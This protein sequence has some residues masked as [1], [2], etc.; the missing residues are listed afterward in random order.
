[1]ICPSCHTPNRDGGRFCIS[2]GYTLPRPPVSTPIQAYQEP[3]PAFTPSGPPAGYPA[4]GGYAPSAPVYAPVQPTPAEAPPA[5]ATIAAPAAVLAPVTRV[6]VTDVNMSF[7]SM[8][9]FMVKWAIASVP[10]LIIL[11]LIIFVIV[12]LFGGVVLGGLF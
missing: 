12:T 11:S 6:V 7:S 8:V 1:M 9:V 5:Q 4:Q 2:C 10:A 3:A